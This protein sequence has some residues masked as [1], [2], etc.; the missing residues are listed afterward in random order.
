MGDAKQGP[1][2]VYAK[3]EGA[4]GFY[5]GRPT[6]WF[7]PYHLVKDLPG[8]RKWLLAQPRLLADLPSLRNQNLAGFHRSPC[9]ID[10]LLELANPRRK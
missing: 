9:Y 2:L 1:K 3:D 10:V 5:V 6:K 4:Y 8:Y 7:P